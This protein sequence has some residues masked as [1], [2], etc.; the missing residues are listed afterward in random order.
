MFHIP[1]KVSHGD[2]RPLGRC[3]S[4][5]HVNCLHPLQALARNMDATT[6]PRDFGGKIAF[7]GGIDTQELLVNGTPKQV[8]DEVRRVKETLGPCV[9]IS[10]SHECI[11]PNVPPVNV[12]AMAEELVN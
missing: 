5:A 8:R 7:M 1:D 4:V 6:L 12:A 9:I 3:E 2:A 11:L 10:P